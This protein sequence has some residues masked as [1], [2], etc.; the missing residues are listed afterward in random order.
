M[1]SD[2]A[3]PIALLL[4]IVSLYAVFHT[5][6]LAPDYDQLQR[7]WPSLDLLAVAAA[8]CLVSDWIFRETAGRASYAHTVRD[9]TS[10]T[11]PLKLFRWASAGMTALFLAS[12]YLETY[13]VFYR[14]VR[15]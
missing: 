3:K 6:F 1:L 11:L 10:T 5:A 4:T 12:W 7:I 9:A 8:I 14:D 13:C 15:Y 2:I